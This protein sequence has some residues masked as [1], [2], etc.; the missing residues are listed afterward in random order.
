M[1][2]REVKTSVVKLQTPLEVNESR[3]ALAQAGVL[4][5]GR[6]CCRSHLMWFPI[7]VG[8]GVDPDE[9]KEGRKWLQVVMGEKG[10][11]C[12]ISGCLMILLFAGFGDIVCGEEKYKGENE[13]VGS[14]LMVGGYLP[15]P[16]RID[17]A[18]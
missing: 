7:H 10:G 8:G 5:G 15:S 11:C 4:G 12:T 14:G 18:R 17:K 1:V 9:L 2:S 3:I 16:R 6:R 13:R